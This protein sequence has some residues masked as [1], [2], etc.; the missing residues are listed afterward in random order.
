MN[1]PRTMSIPSNA[2]FLNKKKEKVLGEDS[3]LEETSD[4]IAFYGLGMLNRLDSECWA[5][6]MRHKNLYGIIVK[7]KTS[8]PTLSQSRLFCLH[9]LLQPMCFY[10][11]ENYKLCQVEPQSPFILVMGCWHH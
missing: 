2:E 8:S 4:H 6:A 5:Q 9:H 1:L 3:S 10:K 7:F 11:V